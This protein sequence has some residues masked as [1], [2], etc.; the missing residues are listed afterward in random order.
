MK[1]LLL[2][3]ALALATSASAGQ[4]GG[5]AVALVTA[6]QQNELIAVELSSG[7][8]LRRVS[9]PA[10]PQNVAALTGR[11]RTAVVVS[12]RT[13][14]VTLLDGRTLKVRKVLGGFAA[15]H[16]VAI[17][18]FGKWAYVT[19]DPRGEL[20]VIALGAKR[21]VNRLFVGTGAHHLS[22]SPGGRRMWIALGE[23]ATEIAIVDLSR[24]TR[25]RL[26]RH[27]SPGFVV[28]DVTFSPD[29]RRV[30]VTS[31]V[32]N[33]VHVLNARSGREVFAVWVGKAPQH[34]AFSDLGVFA[35]FAFATSGYANRIVKVDARTGRV[36]K[37]AST[38]PGSFNLST[39]G[40]LVVTTSLFEGAVTE[41]D[42]NLRRLM[43]TKVA[44]ASRAVALAV[45]P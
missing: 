40:G 21:V 7:K 31:G 38:P 20:V 9:L 12:T 1:R 11:A 33:A 15:P 32:G 8:V 29:G 16:L 2:V 10:D 26:L 28:H 27:F 35:N 5:T 6:E 42:T 39:S 4:T 23:R 13:G 43:S 3:A 36:L 37:T 30:W 19:D 22:I 41:F 25:P 14:A 34:V 44:G 18:P 24:P 45:W 17:S